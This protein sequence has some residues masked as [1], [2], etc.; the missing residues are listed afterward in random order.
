MVRKNKQTKQEKLNAMHEK[1]KFKKEIITVVILLVVI[2]GFYFLV[3]NNNSN[4]KKSDLNIN[5]TGL[6][7]KGVHWHPNLKIKIDNKFINIPNGIGI[8]P[9]RHYPMHTHDEGDGTLHIE[10]SNPK[11]NPDS[12]ALGY[13]FNLWKKPFNSTCILDKCTNIDGGKLHMYVNGKENF[14]FENYVFKGEEKVLI[15][16]NSSKN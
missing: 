8:T 11:S 2:M 5:S 3:S 15:T 1:E 14:D 13:L 4:F 10:N 7:E 6:P 16:Y 12:M 9:S